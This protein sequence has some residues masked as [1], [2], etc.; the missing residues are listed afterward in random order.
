MTII[1]TIHNRESPYTQLNKAVLQDPNL[2]LRSKGLWAFCLSHPDNWQFHVQELITRCQE[3][4]QAIYSAI[5]ELIKNG[6]ALRVDY[7]KRENG[8]LKGGGVEYL[9]FE[10]KATEEDKAKYTEEIKNSLRH[11]DSWNAS[12]RNSRNQQLLNTDSTP[13]TDVCVVCPE[14]GPVDPP[15]IAATAN[16]SKRIEKT[17]SRG[18]KFSISLS[19]L[20]TQSVM[21]KTD[22]TDAEIREAW[23]ILASYQGIIRDWFRFVEGTINNLRKKDLIEKLRTTN[24]ASTK[25]RKQRCRNSKNII[26]LPPS[27]KLSENSNCKISN[28]VTLEQAFPDWRRILESPKN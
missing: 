22:W 6:Y 11:V 12:F 21:H 26:N 7:Q 3:G 14:S 23:E 4:R 5:K 1:R 2:S 20:Y 17:G 27:K 18:E 15:P 9:F 10:F 28:P 13:N 19:D 16:E 8:K 24:I 25:Q